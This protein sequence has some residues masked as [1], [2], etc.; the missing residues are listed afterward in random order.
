MTKK[1][2][3]KEID[4]ALKEI[5]ELRGTICRSFGLSILATYWEETKIP[6]VK[7]I[8]EGAA[9]DKF[10]SSS[11][12]LEDMRRETLLRFKNFKIEI[13]KYVN[14]SLGNYQ[15]NEFVECEISGAVLLKETAFRGRDILIVENDYDAPHVWDKE[16]KQMNY[17]HKE[18]HRPAY[19][20]KN[21]TEGIT[22]YAET[23]NEKEN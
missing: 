7:S 23:E 13:Y 17:T 11:E 16:A 21:L 10:R 2:L 8:A 12:K 3:K 15:K 22:P 19:Y 1:K 14:E 20:A 4:G 5:R 18:T 6:T 9:R